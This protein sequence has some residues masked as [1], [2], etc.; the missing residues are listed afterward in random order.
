MNLPICFFGKLTA[1]KGKK[2]AKHQIL[3]FV[4]LLRAVKSEPMGEFMPTARAR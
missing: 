3:G 1:E 4:D 2:T